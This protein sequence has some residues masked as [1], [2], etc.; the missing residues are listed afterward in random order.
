MMPSAWIDTMTEPPRRLPDNLNDAIAYLSA[1]LGVPVYE[2]WTPAGLA[3]RYGS[4]AA[5]KRANPEVFRLLVDAPE[6]VQFW[7]AGSVVALPRGQAPDPGTTVERLL[8]ALSSRFRPI[9]AAKTARAADNGPLRDESRRPGA[10]ALSLDGDRQWLARTGRFF[11]TDA[12]TNTL[13]A[14]DDA[15]ALAAFMADR[16][17]GSPHTRR[18]YVTELKR[19]IAWCRSQDIG[20]P[21]GLSRENLIMYREALPGVTAHTT[22]R[23]LGPSSC[24]RALAVV[25]SLYQFWTRTGY[26]RA[27]PAV[28]L[29]DKSNGRSTFEPKRFLADTATEACDQ[30]IAAWLDDTQASPKRNRRTLVLALYRYTG[31]RLAELASENGFPHLLVDGMDWSLEVMGKGQRVRRIP[32]PAQCVR[33]IQRYRKSRGLPPVPSP[34]EDM[35]LIHAKR[36]YG[37]GHSGLYR[38]VKTAFQEIADGLPQNDIVGRL[39]FQ[40]ASTHWLRHSYMHHLVVKHQ[41]PLPAAQA[42]AGHASV[43]TTAAYALTDQSQ[44]RKFVSESFGDEPASSNSPTS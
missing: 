1:A 18:A 27:N 15:T 9:Q 28:E 29:G 17:N 44:L 14:T 6:V 35:P 36:G 4:M 20:P 38:E 5:A 41:V 24:A 23:T 21:S 19:F 30:W 26:L 40:V 33:C 31:A 34:I 2:R 10:A 11:N 43:Q 39:A 12:A 22:A 25:K 3:R 7:A 8:R 13:S 37:L 32:L 42:L 16:A